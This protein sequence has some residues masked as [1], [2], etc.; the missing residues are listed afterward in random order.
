MAKGLVEHRGVEAS[1]GGRPPVVL[2]F[3]GSA[4]VVERVERALPAGRSPRGLAVYRSVVDELVRQGEERGTPPLAVGVSVTGIVTPTDAISGLDPA[5]WAEL[6]VDDLAEGRDVE[7]VVENDANALAIGELH[8]GIGRQ[9]P[10]SVT[11]LLERGLGAGIV[12]NGSVYRGHNLAA[13]E[14]GLLLVGRHRSTSASR[15]PVI[16]R[17]A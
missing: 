6:R 7:V 2:A 11:V 5:R 8:R 3:A 17:R 12:T 4:R 13:G 16:S 9:S 14:I 1:T 10:N 15:T